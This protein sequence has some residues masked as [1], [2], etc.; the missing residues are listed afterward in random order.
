MRLERFDN[1]HWL[2]F[3][4]QQELDLDQLRYNVTLYDEVRH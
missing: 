3:T 4:A 2:R 1:N